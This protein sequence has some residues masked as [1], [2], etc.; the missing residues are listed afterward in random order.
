MVVD[1]GY[2]SGVGGLRNVA[3]DWVVVFPG[4]FFS[5]GIERLEFLVESAGIEMT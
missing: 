5:Q 2:R 4:F 1:A 3:R